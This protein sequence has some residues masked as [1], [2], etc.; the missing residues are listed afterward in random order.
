[1]PYLLSHSLSP[2]EIERERE[3]ERERESKR[4][5]KRERERESFFVCEVKERERGCIV[6]LTGSTGYLK[7]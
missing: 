1:M 5:R 4:E 2:G 7:M 6:F 3:R